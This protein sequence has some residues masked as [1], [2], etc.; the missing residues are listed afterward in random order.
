MNDPEDKNEVL[1]ALLICWVVWFLS[2][3][4]GTLPLPLP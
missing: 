3:E 1:W 4:A 2:F